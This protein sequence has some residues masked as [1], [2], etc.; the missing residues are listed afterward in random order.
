MAEFRTALY[1]FLKASHG[2][3]GSFLEGKRIFTLMQKNFF[4]YESLCT[5]PRFDKKNDKTNLEMA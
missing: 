4:S 3:Y 1:L 5:K 2:T